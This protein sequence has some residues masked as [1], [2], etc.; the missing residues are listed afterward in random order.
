M[1]LI[2]LA[3]PYTHSDPWVR[4][5]RYEQVFFATSKMMLNGLKVFSPIVYTHHLDRMLGEGMTH[6]DWL[7]QVLPYLHR[8]DRFVVLKLDGWERSK[9]IQQETEEADKL[10]LKPEYLDV[11]DVDNF[12]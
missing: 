7:L 6:R 9:G 12:Q 2:Y 5:D 10:G 11:L 4:Q 1:K 8:S 3:S